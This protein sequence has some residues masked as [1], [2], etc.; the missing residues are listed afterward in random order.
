MVREIPEGVSFDFPPAVDIPEDPVAALE[1]LY[2]EFETPAVEGI[3]FRTRFDWQNSRQCW[4]WSLQH[5]GVGQVIP[6]VPDTPVPE[7]DKEAYV[8]CLVNYPYTYRDHYRVIF[9]DDSWTHDRVSGSLLGNE[10]KML[11]FPGPDNDAYQGV[12]YEASESDRLYSQLTRETV[13]YEPW[14]AV[15]GIPPHKAFEVDR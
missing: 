2:L 7:E 3:I 4:F 5:M 12:E 1:P 8:P 13:E 11:V 15:L 6:K 9:Y 14:M 10:I